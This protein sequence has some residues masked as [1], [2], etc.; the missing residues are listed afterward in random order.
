MDD[1]LYPP[2]SADAPPEVTRVTLAYRV[3]VVAMVAGLFGFLLVYLL[4]IAAAGLFGYWLLTLPTEVELLKIG[5][6]LATGLLFLFLVKGLFKWRRVERQAHIELREVAHPQ[7]FAFIRRVHAEAGAPPPRRVVVSPD[8]N[9]ALIHDVSMINLVVPPRRDLLIGLGL[10]NTLNLSEFKAVLA[11]EFGHFSQRSVGLSRYLHVANQV[12][13]DLIHRRDSLDRLVDGWARVDLRISFPAWALKGAFWAIRQ[14]LAGIYRGMNLLH[15]SLARQMEFNADNVAVS[16]SGSDAIV[17][18]LY[19]LEFANECFADA[20]QALDAAA[21]HGL[22]TD[23]LFF[24]LSRSADHLRVVRRNERLGIP[25]DEGTVFAPTDDGIP[26]RYRSHPT[27]EMRERNA[28]RFQIPGTNDERSPW[29]LIGAAAE[30]KRATTASFYQF[31]LGRREEYEP[32]PA[33]IVQAFIDA[34]H[35]ETTFDPKYHG[36][37]DDRYLGP[38]DVDAAFEPWSNE[39]AADWVKQWPPADLGDRHRAFRERQGEFNKLHLLKN[40]QQPVKSRTFSFRG[41]ERDFRELKGLMATVELELKSNQEEFDALDRDVFLAHR[42]LA[43]C[44]DADGGQREAELIERYRFHS[45]E[46]GLLK[47]MIDEQNRLRSILDYLAEH[48]QMRAH[49]FY[50]VKAALEEIQT[51][52]TINLD[53]AKRFQ[54]PALTNLPAGSNLYDFIVDRT[55]IRL[56]NWYGDTI[57]GESIGKLLT[58]LHGVVNRIRRLDRKSLG[59][60][61]AFQERL[62]KAVVPAA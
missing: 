7:L 35:A 30:L 11:H 43:R 57:S 40:G 52:L 59:A 5:G 41:A 28:K 61:L 58:R 34:E 17:R 29:L 60:L 9:A 14:L 23:D 25:P 24:H 3:R 1:P 31:T 54:T 36:W 10:L 55:A 38:I 19:R 8:I 39:R 62:V 2:A 15:L 13:C 42:S 21:D 20:A 12:I 53:D 18:G 22:F 4:L 51:S 45:I 16:L 44:L 46:Q 47:G 50:A 56:D 49:Q 33:K 37:Y 27:H 6:V 48:R 26:D 32:Q